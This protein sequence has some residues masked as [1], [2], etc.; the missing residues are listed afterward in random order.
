M[1]LVTL[2]LDLMFQFDCVNM[3]KDFFP[4][5]TRNNLG[6][7]LDTIFG[8]L[9]HLDNQVEFVIGVTATEYAEFWVNNMRGKYGNCRVLDIVPLYPLPKF[10]RPE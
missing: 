5:Q 2:R 6:S 10:F 1:Y 3:L 8:N 7:M 4:I 9:N